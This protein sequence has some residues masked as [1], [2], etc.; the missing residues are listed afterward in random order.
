MSQHFL[1]PFLSLRWRAI[2]LLA[3][4][5]VVL[6]LVFDARRLSDGL[7]LSVHLDALKSHL[8]GSTAGSTTAETETETEE[9]MIR[10]AYPQLPPPDEEEYVAICMAV[11]NQHLDLPEFLVSLHS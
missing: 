5:L 10:K 6:H 9:E 8:P 4:T 1:Q 11:K 7:H 3:I 2:G